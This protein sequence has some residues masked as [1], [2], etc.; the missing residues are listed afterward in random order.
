MRYFGLETAFG[1]EL[2]P[3]FLSWLDGLNDWFPNP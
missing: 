3:T 1:D 2:V